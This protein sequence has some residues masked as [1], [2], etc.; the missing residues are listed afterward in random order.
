MDK[1]SNR[2]QLIRSSPP[3]PPGYAIE[4]DFVQ[5]DRIGICFARSE[6]MGR[7]FPAPD[8]S[9]AQQGRKKLRRTRPDCGHLSAA[10][11]V[12]RFRRASR[13]G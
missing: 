1:V 5:T 9:M 13:A 8:K 7:V 3:P 6:K 11:K 12:K 10:L 2:Q 4:Y